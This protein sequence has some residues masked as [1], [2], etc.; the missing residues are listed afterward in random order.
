MFFIPGWLL[1]LVTFPGV[2]VHEIAHRFF[3]DV[4]DTPVYEVAYFRPGQNPAGYVI[5]GPAK[6]LRAGLLISAGPLLI[7]TVLCSDL[8]LHGRV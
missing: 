1:A 8:D 4:T 3:C 5:H 6:N 2:I 7:N